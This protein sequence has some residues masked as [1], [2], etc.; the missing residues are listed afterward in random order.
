MHNEDIKPRPDTTAGNLSQTVRT[1]NPD[2]QELDYLEVFENSP[3]PTMI[4]AE[5]YTLIKANKSFYKLLKAKPEQMLKT[6]K[7]LEYIEKQDLDMVR[8][9]H[10]MRRKQPGLAPSNYHLRLITENE[11]ET[12]VWVSVEMIPGTALSIATL[13]DITIQKQMETRMSYRL[14]LDE[15]LSEASRILISYGNDNIDNLLRL[16][17]EGMKVSRVI[18]YTF[19]Q[20]ATK[21]DNTYEWCDKGV[22]PKKDDFQDVDTALF[23]TWIKSI[24]AGQ[25]YAITNAQKE[26]PSSTEEWKIIRSWGV[27]S[28]ACAPI[29]SP[30]GEIAGFIGIMNHKNIQP[31]LEEDCLALKI[32]AEMLGLYWERK[33]AELMLKRY[34]TIYENA[35]DVIM[36]IKEDESII[37]VNNEA[38][39]AYG[40]GLETLLSMHALD[41][42]ALSHRNIPIPKPPENE[43][44]GI[45]YETLHRRR[46]GDTFPVE[47]SI[48]AIILNGERLYLC[49]IRDISLRKKT[50][51]LLL[52]LNRALDNS[53]NAV[54]LSDPQGKKLYYQ[55]KA[56]NALFGYTLQEINNRGGL[57]SLFPDKEQARM[58]Y[59]KLHEGNVWQGELDLYTRD[60]T[61]VPVVL[62][63]DRIINEEGEVMGLFGIYTDIRERKLNEIALANEKERL[64]V[65]LNSIADGVMAT[66]ETGRVI[67]IN[68]VA[69]KIIGWKKEEAIG[70]NLA[71]VLE[72]TYGRGLELEKKN[73]NDLWTVL[74]SPQHT[75]CLVQQALLVDRKGKTKTVFISIA[76][77]LNNYHMFIGHVLV[78]RDISELIKAQMKTNLS[79]KLESIG[80][81]AAG[82]AHEINSPLQYIGDNISFIQEST[83]Q[84]VRLVEI[85]RGMFLGTVDLNDEKAAARIRQAEEEVEIDYLLEEMPRAIK[86]TLDGIERVK[87][88]VL[89]MKEFSHPGSKE[90]KL[91]DLNR[92]IEATINI[93]RNEWKYIADMET[94]LAPALPMVNCVIDEINQVVLN[95]IINAAQAI[96][97]AAAMGRYHRGIIKVSSGLRDGNVEIKV[98]DNGVG[99]P[100]SII[101]KI[102]DPF[103]TTKP[104]GQGTGQG[105]AIAHDIIVNKHRGTIDVYS[106]EGEGTTFVISLPLN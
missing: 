5:D 34:H 17:G 39:K 96:K 54:M 65:T 84:M 48:Q 13:T 4:L 33:H 24:M 12:N 73:E 90:K 8:S 46:D 32:V 9:Y 51:E 1:Q 103:F 47:I 80:S 102:Y 68:A 85:Y 52:S 98:S 105:L 42:R 62:Y 82:I 58:L 77:I 76:P 18:I 57:P 27:Y 6:S 83:C 81:L 2:E 91:S 43:A 23:P 92:G 59:M 26:I 89:A 79:Q 49:I 74:N 93:S 70:L 15:V 60:G 36:L 64:A 44:S 19:R 30:S 22:I 88:L 75:E 87:K 37:D 55:N 99:I 41:L 35:R 7:W 71:D 94:S 63:A 104:I 61:M 25:T 53:S 21:M 50:E 28:M 16:I 10:Q 95:V 29:I 3:I 106:K 78:I 100:D 97:E 38:C 56:F 72:F 20:Q 31:W 66:D 101:S 45:L 67:T 40:Y 11:K 14:S 69:E 86:E